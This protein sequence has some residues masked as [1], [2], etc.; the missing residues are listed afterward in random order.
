MRYLPSAEIRQ[1]DLPVE[2]SFGLATHW[3]VVD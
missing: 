1:F 3:I 2:P